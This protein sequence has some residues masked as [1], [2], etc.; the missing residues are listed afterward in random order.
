MAPSAQAEKRLLWHPRWEN[1]F[2]VG[3]GSQMTMYEWAPEKSEIRQVTSQN[4]LQFMKVSPVPADVSA[5]MNH[6]P[7]VFC[8]VS[9]P[10]L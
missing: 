10:R 9:R 3:G 8:L 1:K 7:T 2:V 4:D 5:T 6:P